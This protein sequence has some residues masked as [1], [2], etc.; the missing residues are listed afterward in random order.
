MK[1]PTKALLTVGLAVIGTGCGRLQDDDAEARNRSGEAGKRVEALGNSVGNGG[2]ALVCHAPESVQFFDVYEAATLRGVSVSFGDSGGSVQDKVSFAIE[3]LRAV[4]P[5]RAA[6]YADD[7]DKFWGDVVFLHGTSLPGIADTGNVYVPNTCTV[8]QIV[9]QKKPD[10]P[11]DKRYVIDGDLWD[12]L[13]AEDQAALVLHE[14]I[15]KDAIAHGQRDSRR[16][17]YFNS[18]VFS[19]Q[20]AGMSAGDYSVLVRAAGLDFFEIWDDYGSRALGIFY[21]EKVTLALAEQTCR[22]GGRT[23]YS[24]CDATEGSIAQSSAGQFLSQLPADEQWLWVK[25]QQGSTGTVG[26]FSGSN[27]TWDRRAE[28][29]SALHGFICK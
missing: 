9:I 5:S 3:R 13:S 28:P 29:V 10:L 25:P 11:G 8:A 15:Y 27:A 21:P 16:V 17:R 6:Q 4:D 18:V 19:T 20:L 14:V 26:H 22:D 12:R 23:L 7:A 2:D 24:G 1:F